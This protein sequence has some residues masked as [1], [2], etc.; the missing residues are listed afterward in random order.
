MVLHSPGRGGKLS[1]W[2]G[3]TGPWCLRSFASLA[4]LNW[5]VVLRNLLCQVEPGA[6]SMPPG[7]WDSPQATTYAFACF[8]LA[9]KYTRTLMMLPGG[10]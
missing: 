2:L 4:F 8:Y 9:A 7:P 3:E 6:K 1:G 10:G 5:H